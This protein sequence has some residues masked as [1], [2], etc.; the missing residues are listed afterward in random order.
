MGADHLLPQVE[1]EALIAHKAFDAEQR[2]IQRLRAA[3]KTPVTK[4]R[5]KAP[6][7]EVLN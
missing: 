7:E 6:S 2:V 4:Q 1:A 3:G 5:R